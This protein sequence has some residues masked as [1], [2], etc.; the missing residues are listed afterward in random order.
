[1]FLSNL[2]FKK[3]KKQLLSINLIIESFFDNFKKLKNLKEIKNKKNYKT[4]RIIF[5]CTILTIILFLSY[6]LIPSLYNKNKIKISIQNQ[7]LDQYSIK[8]QFSEKVKYG[9]FPEPHF[10]TKNLS[11]INKGKNIALVGKSKIFI[12]YKNFF[13]FKDLKVK[14]LLLKNTDFKI[15]KNDIDFFE[16]VL[17]TNNSKYKVKIINSNLFFQNKDEEIIFLSKIKNINFYYDSKRFENKLSSNYEIFNIPFHLNVKNHQSDKKLSIKINSDKIRLNI[18]NTI[19]YTDKTLVGTLDLA[20]IN[21]ENF[22]NYKINSDS[23]NFKSLSN[24]T[25]GSINF[26]PFYL[27]AHSYFD[28]LDLK[29]FFSHDS[30]FVNFIKSEI[31]NNKNLNMDIV[32]KFKNIKN[33][34]FLSD[35]I[36]KTYL[37]EG[38]LVISNSSVNWKDA[39]DIKMFDAQINNSDDDINLIGKIVLKFNKPNKFYSAF[40]VNK[41][42]RKSLEIIEFD[43]IYELTKQN[44][45]LDNVRINNDS[46]TKLEKF[47]DNFNT[48]G[49]ILNNKIIFK[50]F[51]N[52]F[53]KAYSG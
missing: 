32:F 6:F 12:S 37:E 26:K 47:I 31:I 10:S 29:N 45:Y 42:F 1:M 33:N 39:V 38:N 4:Y 43:F 30:L 18:E 3:L 21:K 19:D 41:L 40:Q 11:I 24:N 15:S 23:L 17:N 53:F 14:N 52:D 7:L 36:L 35:L 49:N 44:L 2:F 16:K 25:K 9:L 51:I 13:S 8:I 34:K 5:I 50:S 27:S 22:I 48:S 28:Q 46:I 20:T